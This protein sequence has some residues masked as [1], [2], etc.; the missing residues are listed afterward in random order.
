MMIFRYNQNCILGG[1][2]VYN[3]QQF[4]LEENYDIIQLYLLKFYIFYTYFY[5]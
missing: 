1:S 5:I 4:F 2:C 3:I